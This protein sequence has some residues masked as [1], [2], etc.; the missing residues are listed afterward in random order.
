MIGSL[1]IQ[2]TASL[3]TARTGTTQLNNFDSCNKISLYV[4]AK[5]KKSISYYTFC[6]L[7]VFLAVHVRP[8]FCSV[9]QSLGALLTVAGANGKPG[10]SV[11]LLAV[12]GSSPGNASVIIH[13]LRVVEEAAWESMSSRKTA[14]YTHAQVVGLTRQS[15]LKLEFLD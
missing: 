1:Q 13:L 4:C 15:G 9:S 10:P 7:S 12:E 14:T 11:R 2:E 8:G 5:N 3:V 6:W